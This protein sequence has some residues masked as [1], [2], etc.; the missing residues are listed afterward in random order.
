MPLV[1]QLRHHPDSI[2]ERTCL[3]AR[4]ITV[5]SHD[6]DNLMV[7]LYVW[8]YFNHN[9]E[10][11]ARAV[12]IAAFKPFWPDNLPFIMTL[13]DAIIQRIKRPKGNAPRHAP[14]FSY[15]SERT[16][17]WYPDITTVILSGWAER[18]PAHDCSS[19]CIGACNTTRW[20][21]KISKRSR[22]ANFKTET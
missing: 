21:L 6:V 13:V 3:G 7:L 17:G 19:R 10:L 22:K 16:R 8:D 11:R 18:S 20:F 1:G 14:L 5:E 2:Q 15:P 12:W 9:Y 4:W